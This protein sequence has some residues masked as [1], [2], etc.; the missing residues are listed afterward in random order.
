MA[1]S[2][3]G[4]DTGLNIDAQFA[5][6]RAENPLS[7]HLENTL[8][9]GLWQYACQ[10]Y[11]QAGVEA[12]LLA[13]QDDHGADINLILQALWL[14]SEGKQWTK[15][16]IPTDYDQ[17]M[18]EQVLPLRQMRRSMKVEW[19]EKRGSQY[20]GFRQQVKKLELNAEQHALAM[21][22]ALSD[23]EAKSDTGLVIANLAQLAEYSE[24]SR[25]KF[26][27]LISLI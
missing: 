4:L 18:E 8:D 7:E 26:E 27:P 16:Y 1:D 15:A 6:N 5:T 17:W 20:E 3:N 25:E 9:N 23:Q 19:V 10:V 12:A 14:A 11:S 24:L 21:L 2:Q 13:L 22:F